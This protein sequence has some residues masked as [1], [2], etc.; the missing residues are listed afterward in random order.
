MIDFVKKNDAISIFS[1]NFAG[2]ENIIHDKIIRVKISFESSFDS[3]RE[4]NSFCHYQIS[5]KI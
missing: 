4:K 1:M 3:R 2:F 5:S